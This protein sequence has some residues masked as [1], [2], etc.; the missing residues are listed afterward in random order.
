MSPLLIGALVVGVALLAW[1]TQR[2]QGEANA[3]YNRRRDEK[4]ADAMIAAMRRE[5]AAKNAAKD[6]RAD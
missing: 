5:L 3:E 6:E 4:K 2:G 1:I